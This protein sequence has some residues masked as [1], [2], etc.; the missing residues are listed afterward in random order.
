MDKEPTDDKGP[1]PPSRVDMFEQGGNHWPIVDCTLILPNDL[2]FWCLHCQEDHWHGAGGSDIASRMKLGDLAGHRGAHCKDRN[3]WPHGYC[4]RVT[5]IREPTPSTAKRG[6]QRKDALTEWFWKASTIGV[7]PG[8]LPAV[9]KVLGER[10]NMNSL[11]T[12]EQA[13]QIVGYVAKHDDDFML[14]RVV[15]DTSNEWRPLCICNSRKHTIAVPACGTLLGSLVSELALLHVRG[16]DDCGAKYRRRKA[17]LQR[18]V[19]AAAQEL[20]NE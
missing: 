6:R 19:L 13:R 5:E 10:P 7:D 1:P 16:F 14:V 4:L 15:P 20:G 3:V 12:I 9:V 18:L 8:P 11:L 2:T 17:L